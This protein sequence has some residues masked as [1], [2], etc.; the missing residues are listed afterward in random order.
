M[1]ENGVFGDDD[2]G[3]ADDIFEQIDHFVLQ[4]TKPAQVCNGFFAKLTR[5]RAY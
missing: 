2:W 1:I 5:F 4:H 3:D